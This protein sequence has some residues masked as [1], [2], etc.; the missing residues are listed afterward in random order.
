MLFKKQQQNICTNNCQEIWLLKKEVKS[1][2]TSISFSLCL[3]PPPPL[4][5][6]IQENSIMIIAINVYCLF[7]VYK[8]QGWGQGSSAKMGKTMFL[9]PSTGLS[10]E[11]RWTPTWKAINEAD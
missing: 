1:S 11:G 4:P 8:A 10:N 5:L 6:P 9:A 2:D 7:T 3:H